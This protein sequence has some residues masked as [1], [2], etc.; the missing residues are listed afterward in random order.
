MRT[1]SI[2]NC[3][4]TLKAVTMDDIEVARMVLICS[5]CKQLIVLCPFCT[6]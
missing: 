4:C 5:E 1:M 3:I 2:Y 6:K